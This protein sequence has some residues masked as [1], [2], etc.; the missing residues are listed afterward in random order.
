MLAPRRWTPRRRLA[1]ALVVLL[2]AGGIVAGVLTQ[3][4]PACQQALIPA[5]FYPGAD[6]AEAIASKPPP[7]I[8]IMDMT[9]SGAGTAPDRN[10]Q[11]VAR[12]ARAA[13]ITLAGYSDTDYGR[14][15]AAAV[16]ADV[17]HYK[18]WYGVSDIF[19]DRASSSAGDLAYYRELSAYIH[20]AIPGSLVILNPGDYPD[21]SYMSAGDIIVT[22]EGSYAQYATLA[23]PHWADGYPAARFAALIYAVPA[24]GLPRSFDAARR[25][26]VGYVYVTSQ[27]GINP[28]GSLPG[29]WASEDTIIAA[30]AG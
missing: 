15:P 24:T 4:G 27:S 26:N 1:A 29:Y 28:Y 20:R 5:Y 25:R 9:S 17:L 6:W 10:Y 13:G 11:A 7:K 18:S 21:Q 8:M 30:C 12:R 23:V 14:R 22:F 16:E 19:L 3:S 2:A